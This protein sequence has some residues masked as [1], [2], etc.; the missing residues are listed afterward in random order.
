MLGFNLI[1]VTDKVEELNAELDDMMDFFASSLSSSS[2][3]SATGGGWR[4]PHVG[5]TFPF[6]EL[7]EAVRALQ[8]GATMGK[9]VVTID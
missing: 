3:S 9:V 7:P 6:D 1:W 5:S 4:P 8:S 2:S